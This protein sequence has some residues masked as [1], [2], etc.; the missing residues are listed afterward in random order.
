MTVT[1]LYHDVVRVRQDDASGFPGPGAARYKLTITEFQTHLAALDQAARL[2][3]SVLIEEAARWRLTFDDGGISAATY[4]ADALDARD[5]RGWFFITTD[6]IGTAGFVSRTQLLDLYQRGHMLGTHSCSHPSPFAHLPYARQVAELRDSRKLLED[7]L[8]VGV[9]SGSV[10]GGFYSA[11][12]GDAAAEAGLT[13]L[14]NSEPTTTH[15]ERNGC[16]IR[17]RYTIYRGMTAQHAVG[18][19]NSPWARGRQAWL[20]SAKKL[21]KRTAGS[22]YRQVREAW[23]RRSYQ[24]TPTGP[25]ARS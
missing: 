23:L 16:R 14:F 2:A 10:P 13:T 15:D 18:L 19:L 5:W 8:G 21:A 12:V 22:A 1:L 25:A 17:G 24:P 11:E 3:P 6:R 9:T 4:I 20:W 7:I